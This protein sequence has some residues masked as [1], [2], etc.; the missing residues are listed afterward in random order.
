MRSIAVLLVAALASLLVAVQARGDDGAPWTGDWDFTWSAGGAHA[1]LIQ[2]GDTVAGEVLL[3]GSKI[4]GKVAGNR[5]TGARIEA[6][7]SHELVLLI[8]S[9]GKALVGYDHSRG[10]VTATRITTDT[11]PPAPPLDSP[12]A[13]FAEFTFVANQLRLG[14]DGYWNRLIG[15]VEFAPEALALVPEERLSQLRS[16]FELVDLTTF[17]VREIPAES[18]HD[19]VTVALRQLKSDAV[20]PIVLRRAADKTWRVVVPNE[21]GIVASRKALLAVHGAKP[22]TEQSFRALQSPRDAVRTFLEGMVKWHSGGSETALSTL[23]LGVLPEALRQL[24]GRLAAGYLCRSLDHIGF[25]ELQSIP[26]DPTNRDP[27]VL[28]EHP[29][30]SIV[31]APSG[32]EPDAPWKF[33][34]ETVDSIR[35]VYFMTSG[36]PARQ[37]SSLGAIPSTAAF[38][39]RGFFEER[40]PFL[41]A[42]SIGFEAWQAL[43]LVVLMLSSIGIGRIA[44][45]TICWVLRRIT[46]SIAPMPA[47]LRDAIWLLCTVAMLYPVSGI[48]GLPHR[49]QHEFVP[50]VGT[51]VSIAAAIVAWYLVAILC[52]LLARAAGR[53]DDLALNLLR[54]C[55]RVGVVAG[56]CVA[57][58]Y[59]WSIPATNVLA[60]VGIGGIGIAF[61]SQQTIAQFFGA[62]VLVGDRAFTV[63][64]WIQF[65]S[66]VACTLSGVVEGV[67]FRSTR[68]RSADG[69]VLSVPNGALA[70]VTIVNFGRHR[71]RP[72]SLQITVTQGATLE[73]V[74]R[75]TATLRGR[76]SASPAF[77]AG[78]ASVGVAG[79]VRDGILVQCNALLAAKTDQEDAD[80]RHAFLV[81]VMALAD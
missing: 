39:L 28:F 6:G 62:G 42:R 11:V 40:F 24:D 52:T 80:A 63:G 27:V 58:A 30:G 51:L 21:D 43:L 59:F 57:A 19:E 7:R 38:A 54:G 41:L 16:Y 5:F 8:E 44:A 69:S 73:R 78:S 74:E 25:R 12:R 15:S 72:L 26:N 81:E 67:G 4:E 50:V 32:P 68:I 14:L 46:H 36:L 1:R 77:L 29:E 79:I 61:A 47:L 23:D 37:D 48:L 55:L 60:G 75:F 45:G 53:A 66:G 20:L 18:A 71:P 9:G 70:S 17:D 35:R 31:V 65:N 22:P 76:M 49:H 13:A 3:V 2:T 64:D 10:W 56:A 33:T 34:G